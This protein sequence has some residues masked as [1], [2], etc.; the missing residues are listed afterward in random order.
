MYK[1]NDTYYSDILFSYNFV[2]NCVIYGDVDMEF[3]D[4][5]YNFNFIDIYLIIKKLHYEIVSRYNSE[6]LMALELVLIKHCKSPIILLNDREI[7]KDV[8]KNLKA[9]GITDWFLDNVTFVDISKIFKKLCINLKIENYAELFNYTDNTL[10]E[11]LKHITLPSFEF[12]EIYK[13]M[14]VAEHRAHKFKVR[15]NAR[16]GGKIAKQNYDKAFEIR[17][18]Y[19]KKQLRFNSDLIDIQYKLT[20]AN[21]SGNQKLSRL[22]RTELINNL[23]IIDYEYCQL[24]E[25]KGYD[26]S[27]LE[28]LKN[29]YTSPKRNILNLTDCGVGRKITKILS[30]WLKSQ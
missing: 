26:F 17:F 19:L 2:I 1:M 4:K 29:R 5:H 15:M 30:T 3:I 8:I 12:K 28:E 23:V 27:S 25:I 7:P 6:A 9:H 16:L 21:K 20:A 11:K 18:K 13:M 14:M 10:I 22:S 24:K